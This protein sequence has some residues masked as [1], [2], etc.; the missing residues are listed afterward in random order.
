MKYNA[1]DPITGKKIKGEFV[2]YFNDNRPMHVMDS[3]TVNMNHADPR[4]A[5]LFMDWMKQQNA[6]KAGI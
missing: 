4:N 1:V 2:E 5:K 3:V 6:G